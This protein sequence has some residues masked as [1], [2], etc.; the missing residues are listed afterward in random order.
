M[1]SVSIIDLRHRQ[2]LQQQPLSNM[3]CN[4]T[5]QHQVVMELPMDFSP[6]QAPSSSQSKDKKNSTPQ[7]SRSGKK[8][9]S[10]KLLGSKSLSNMMPKN[11]FFR[12]SKDNENKQ[13]QQQQKIISNQNCKHLTN[14][15]SFPSATYNYPFNRQSTLIMP[16]SEQLMPINENV[17]VNRK[18]CLNPFLDEFEPLEEEFGRI[19]L[20]KTNSPSNTTDS[21]IG[22]ISIV[23]SSVRI[24][25]R[26]NKSID[27]SK[28]ETK[29]KL[30]K[31]ATKN[32]FGFKT[33]GQVLKDVKNSI[34]FKLK[35]KKGNKAFKRLQEEAATPST[36][37]YSPF[38]LYDNYSES[39]N[40]SLSSNS[41]F[42][43][44]D[45]TPKRRVALQHKKHVTNKFSFESPTGKFKDTVKDVENFQQCIE[46]ISKAIKSR[47]NRKVSPLAL[48]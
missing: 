32:A 30:P 28:A 19:R 31:D 24:L 25:Q 35:S 27:S 2:N 22:S 21:G 38:S 3:A 29:E 12:R 18:R 40:T 23:E 36:K 37:L 14:F 7:Q 43:Q 44:T 46:D 6:I 13:H 42:N 16:T 48:I 15:K 47:D 11:L 10:A 33:T 41:S 1:H 5:M 4:N 20:K 17:S 45:Q 39:R 34:G 26:Q 8:Q 9:K